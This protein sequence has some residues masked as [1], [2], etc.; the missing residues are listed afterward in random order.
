[1]PKLNSIQDAYNKWAESYEH[2]ENQTREL[3]HYILETHL[4]ELPKGE[5]LDLGCGTGIN[6]PKLATVAENV[7][8][9]DFSEKMLARAKQ[10]PLPP[11]VWLVQH[12]ILE[13]WPFL[14][15]SFEAINISLVL[16]HI[17]DLTLVF[18]ECFRTLKPNG[19]V[20]VCEY[21]PERQAM[22]KAAKFYDKDE[23]SEHLIS[24]FVHTLAQYKQT[25]EDAGFTLQNEQDWHAPNEANALPQV[26]SFKLCKD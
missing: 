22:G 17:E 11:N 26:L 10:R 24:S 1:M 7:T 14:D 16:E 5:I 23:D 9:M 6:L 8:G 20:L 25:A 12:N 21:H 15:E 19:W 18:K 3:A 13:P 4:E 2:S